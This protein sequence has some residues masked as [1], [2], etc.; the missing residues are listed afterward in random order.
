MK[1]KKTIITVQYTYEIEYKHKDHYLVI[2]KELE[3]RPI[4]EISG[5]GVASN[6]KIYSYSCKRIGDGKIISEVEK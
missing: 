2:R 5:A 1:E 4:V 6:K 3:E